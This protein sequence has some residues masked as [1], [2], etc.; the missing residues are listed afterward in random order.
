MTTRTAKYRCGTCGNPT[1]YETPMCVNCRL[2][3][4]ATKLPWPGRKP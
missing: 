4:A 1:T 3:K 2:K